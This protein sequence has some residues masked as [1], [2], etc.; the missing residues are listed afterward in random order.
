LTCT[1]EKSKEKATVEVIVS[2]ISVISVWENNKEVPQ[3]Y[4]DEI[5]KRNIYTV[6]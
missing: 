1:D 5:E 2:N 6:R 4:W 3:K